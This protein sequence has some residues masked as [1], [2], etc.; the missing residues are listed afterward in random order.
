MY[1]INLFLN[2]SLVDWKK[3]YIFKRISLMC[4]SHWIFLCGENGNNLI[5][6]DNL[7][8]EFD[9]KMWSVFDLCQ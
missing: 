6:L 4:E 2:E 3:L 8:E 7:K 9:L 5:K 1:K